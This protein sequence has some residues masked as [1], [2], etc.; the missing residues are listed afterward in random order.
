MQ[1]KFSEVLN[2]IEEDQLKAASDLL[3]DLVS[4]LEHKKTLVILQRRL[5]E[6][7]TS[8]DRGTLEFEEYSVFRN[9][10]VLTLLDII[11]E[12]EDKPAASA[13][14]T[15]KALQFYR[16]GNINLRNKEFYKAILYLTKAI[17]ANPE[18]PE[19]YLDRGSAKSALGSY[20]EAK[21]DFLIALELS[22][23][24]AFAW[25]NLGI[26]EYRLGNT[27]KAC[28]AWKKVQELGFDIADNNIAQVCTS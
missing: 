17:I 28:K 26:T 18:Y 3:A 14:N 1:A 16:F 4:D 19:A 15:D 25:Y 23:T 8:F 27:Q 5:K 12:S 9:R 6:N 7:K 24:Q 11:S 21:Q 13:Q 20:E 2:L 22:P 10:M